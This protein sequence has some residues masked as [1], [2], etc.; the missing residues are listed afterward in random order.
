MT[1]PIR[2]I[3]LEQ[4]TSP[5][6]RRVLDAA[7]GIGA[8]PGAK[9]SILTAITSQA[10][11]GA[12]AG[13]ALKAGSL[14]LVVKSVAAG[15]V[16][17]VAATAGVSTWLSPQ[18]AASAARAA[19][20][21]A[22][23]VPAPPDLRVARDTSASTPAPLPPIAKAEPAPPRALERAPAG[24]ELPPPPTAAA[25]SQV[26]FS[27]APL[28]AVAPPPAVSAADRAQLESRRVAEAR[29]LLR[30]GR[31]AACLAVLN[32]LMREFPNG[33]LAQERE[34][35]TIEALLG[36]GERERARSLAL[37]FLRVHPNSPLGASVRRALD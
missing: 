17:G 23:R 28:D 34:A 15:V 35:L 36:S 29:G 2:L 1:D 9:A 37:E 30:A 22:L 10:A 25:P 27:D 32:E 16:L 8:P 21:S 4:G 18:P 24:T 33:V 13:A 26:A 31:T 7:K 11:L 20:P 19:A 14:S 5:L 12:S 6:E 3:E